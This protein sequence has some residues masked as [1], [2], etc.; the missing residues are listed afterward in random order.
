MSVCDW[1]NLKLQCKVDIFA[2]ITLNQDIWVPSTLWGG[3]GRGTGCRT[4][5]HDCRQIRTES[6]LQMLWCNLIVLISKLNGVFYCRCKTCFVCTH[7]VSAVDGHRSQ[8]HIPGTGDTV[9]TSA[10]G[11]SNVGP[12][13]QFSISYTALEYSRV[14]QNIL[15][16]FKFK[17]CFSNE[18]FSDKFFCYCIVFQHHSFKQ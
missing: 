16:E 1:C 3:G 5:L 17:H 8:A 4:G 13:W 18:H 11:L 7:T 15:F 2:I 9:V 12:T 14:R 10:W 6:A